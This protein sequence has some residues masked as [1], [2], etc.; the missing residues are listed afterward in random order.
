M[1]KIYR[2]TEKSYV[3]I[4]IAGLYQFPFLLICL[5]LVSLIARSKLLLGWQM[6]GVTLMG[7]KNIK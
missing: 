2:F 4:W 3:S 5:I 6:K 7:T 1:K